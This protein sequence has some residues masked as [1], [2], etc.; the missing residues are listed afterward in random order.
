L[1]DLFRDYTFG[2]AEKTELD[3]DGHYVL[4]GILTATACERLTESLSRIEDLRRER[5]DNFP[6]HHSA[7]CDEYLASLIAH[8]Q[9]VDLA[10]RVLGE[11]IRYDHCVSL[12]RPAGNGGVGWHTHNY[13][14]EMPEL[15]FV[16]I[17]FYV[18]GFEPDD[19]GLK[20]VP[21]S[22]E[23]RQPID[24][25]DD[26]KLRGWLSE[27]RCPATG[28]IME[29]VSLTAPAGTVALM[30]TWALHA[31]SPRRHDSATRWTVVYAYRNPGETSHARWITEE[32]ERNPPPGAESL[33]PLY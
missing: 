31:V 27:H 21:G 23:F 18:N 6:N 17:F 26:D 20:V 28:D 5:D 14:R 30:W 19:G 29:I 24:A 3:R 10:R 11:D 13:A 15:G 4:P 33:M 8:P 1:G 16:R 2:E 25:D 12:N 7:E 22:H 9:L 32:F